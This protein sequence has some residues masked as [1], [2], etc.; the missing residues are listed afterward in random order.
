M[1]IAKIQIK[2]VPEKNCRHQKKLPSGSFLM[3]TKK[4]KISG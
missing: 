1:M 4:L 2:L 3:Q